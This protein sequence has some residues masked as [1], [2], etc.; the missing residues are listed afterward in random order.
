MNSLEE[1]KP[2]YEDFLRS[3]RFNYVDRINT[4]I[5]DYTHEIQ[6]AASGSKSSNVRAGSGM[7]CPRVKVKLNELRSENPALERRMVD[8][9]LRHLRALE[10]AAHDIGKDERPG[11]DDKY[12]E[13]IVNKVLKLLYWKGSIFI[14]I[15]IAWIKI[16]FFPNF[17]RLQISFCLEILIF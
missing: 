17:L 14:C 10:F 9:P 7:G 1:L 8:D 5:D 3:P 16:R 12:G 2:S 15:C 6:T 13:W 4:A 11:Y